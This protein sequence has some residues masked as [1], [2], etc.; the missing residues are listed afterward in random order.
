MRHSR[1]S[2]GFTLIELMVVVAIIGILAAVAIP[3]YQDYT[4]RARVSEGLT[5][6]A[7]AKVQVY[8]NAS[9]GMAQL[10]SGY[11][12]AGM[13]TRAVKSITIDDTNGEIA[14]TYQA[15][16]QAG[17]P[18]LVLAPRQGAVAGPA[19][20]AGTIYTGVLV[21]N[22]NSGGSARAGTTGTLP[23]RFAPAECR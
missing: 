2:S 1:A 21:W 10:S 22:C 16:V 18:T 9:A 14:I 11:T 23:A 7:K 13:V 3:A 19:L 17:D 15:V 5:L 8:E 6:A 20:V 4:V 12:A